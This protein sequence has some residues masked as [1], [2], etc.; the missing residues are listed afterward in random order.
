MI[1]IIMNIILDGR[2]KQNA[3]HEEIILTSMKSRTNK[4]QDTPKMW[5]GRR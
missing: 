2:E 5:S 3:C 4:N 1:F